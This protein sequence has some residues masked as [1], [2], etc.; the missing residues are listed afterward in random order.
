MIPAIKSNKEPMNCY[1]LRFVL[2]SVAIPL[3]EKMMKNQ[4][5]NYFSNFIMDSEEHN[6]AKNI[7]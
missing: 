1:F 7:P 3:V 5:E 6:E 4:K 2:R